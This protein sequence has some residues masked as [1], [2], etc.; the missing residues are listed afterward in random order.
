MQTTTT[1]VA[2]PIP[3]A[4]LERAFMLGFAAVFLANAIV[5]A[6]DPTSFTTLVASSSVGRGLGLVDAPFLGAAICANDAAL[7]VAIVAV[8]TRW[9]RHWR[10]AVL[11]WAGFWLLAVTLVKLTAL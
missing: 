6:V 11:A 10:A 1:P 4:L 3:A 7:G 8:D 2:G 5:A 9:G